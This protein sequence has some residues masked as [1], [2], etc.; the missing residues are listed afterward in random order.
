MRDHRQPAPI[1]L[2]LYIF[3]ILMIYHVSV[4]QDNHF[5][6]FMF[7]ISKICVIPKSRGVWF[8]PFVIQFHTGYYITIELYLYIGCALYQAQC[9]VRMVSKHVETFNLKNSCS[10]RHFFF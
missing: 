4:R 8:Y 7:Y 5:W 6:H 3:F 2:Y 1:H 9:I 10:K